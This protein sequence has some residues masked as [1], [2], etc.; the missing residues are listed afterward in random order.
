MGWCNLGSGTLIKSTA[1]VRTARIFV[2]LSQPNQSRQSAGSF[3]WLIKVIASTTT[4]RVDE[5][6][7]SAAWYGSWQSSGCLIPYFR[8][9]VSGSDSLAS[10]FCY[11]TDNK[12]GFF[13][14][15]PCHLAL[16][17]S[18]DVHTQ[19][20]RRFPYY[21]SDYFVFNLEVDIPISRTASSAEYFLCLASNMSA[22]SVPASGLTSYL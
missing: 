3:V 14:D 9:F 22:I 21:P 2:C 19:N 16:I 17:L 6:D 4:V 5:T 8:P 20:P 11:E 18:E 7:I 1:S 15:F 13:D 10:I 12:L